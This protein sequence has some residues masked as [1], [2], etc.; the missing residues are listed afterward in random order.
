MADSVTI[1]E[2]AKALALSPST[3]NRALTGKTGVKPS[4]K[5]LVIKTAEKMGYRQNKAAS[6]LSRR[7]L[8]V[9]VAL[10]DAVPEFTMDIRRGVEAALKKLAD[11]SVMGELCELSREDDAEEC[12]RKLWKSIDEYAPD[13]VIILPYSYGRQ[14]QDTINEITEKGMPVATYVSDEPSSKRAFTVTRNGER[15]GAYAAEL[16]H[17]IM[18][19]GKQVAIITHSKEGQ[20]HASTI[21]GFTK[22]AHEN[23]MNYIGAFEHYDDPDIAYVLADTILKRYPQIGGLYFNSANSV[24]F[25]R[26]LEEAGRI[27]DIRIIASDISKPIAEMINEGKIDFSIFSDPYLQAKRCVEKMFLLL[28]E[29]RSVVPDRFLIEPQIIMKSNLDLYVNDE[30]KL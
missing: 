24:S 1:Y 30:E 8:K 10:Y 23:A 15:C 11:F 29:G 6:M 4:T 18:P 2:I 13:A 5:E 26:K 3:V 25:C 27:K 21:A 7:L 12:A 19:K 28:T 20:V 17:R 14:M 16:L 22:F 9:L